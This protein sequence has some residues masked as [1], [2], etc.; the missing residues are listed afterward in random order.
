MTKTI[1]QRCLGELNKTGDI[2]LDYVRG[3]LEVLLEMQPGEVAKQVPPETL[4]AILDPKDPASITN[5]EIITR[6]ANI[7]TFSEE[8][9]EVK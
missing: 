5:A 6:L 1:L 3:M 4:R 8:S 7:K 2:R 9:I